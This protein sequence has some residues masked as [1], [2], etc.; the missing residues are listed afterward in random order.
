MYFFNL[1]NFLITL[2]QYFDLPPRRVQRNE[3]IAL[4]ELFEVTALM[5]RIIDKCHRDD[6]LLKLKNC[7]RVNF[8]REKKISIS[9][10]SRL[11]L[12]PLIGRQPT[13]TFERHQTA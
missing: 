9:K 11:Y 3:S 13:T 7:G 6:Y 8:V 4:G 12:S 1:F 5:D 2:C 10:M